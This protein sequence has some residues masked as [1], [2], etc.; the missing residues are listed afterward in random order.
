M[1]DEQQVQVVEESE[2]DQLNG[3]L[4]NDVPEID[5]KL[6]KVISSH[7][8][9]S[10]KTSWNRKHG[11]LTSIIENTI[12]PLNA[13]IATLNGYLETALQEA[14]NIRQEMVDTCIHPHEYLAVQRDQ[15]VECKFCGKRMK[16]IQRDN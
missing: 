8:T 13:E 10:E 14:R 12:N 6:A 7:A 5:S 11:N 3:S 1:S 4:L 2:D 9:Q 15:S 16:V